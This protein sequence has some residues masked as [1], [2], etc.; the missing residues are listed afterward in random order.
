[1]ELITDKEILQLSCKLKVCYH[2]HRNPHLD[3]NLSPVNHGHKMASKCVT[4]SVLVCFYLWSLYHS[5]PG[6]RLPDFFLSCKR[7][8][9]IYSPFCFIWAHMQWTLQVCKY[10]VEQQT[11]QACKALIWTHYLFCQKEEQHLEGKW[12]SCMSVALVEENVPQNIWLHSDVEYVLWIGKVFSV[13][14]V[15]AYRGVE[16]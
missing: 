5:Y 9:H 4:G 14:A 15:K 13:H 3:T 8:M 10:S 6:F 2:V 11:V 1:V 12:K 7:K 16:V